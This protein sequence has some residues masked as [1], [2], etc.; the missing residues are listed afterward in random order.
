MMGK[1]MQALA[2][3]YV[4]AGISPPTNAS[5]SNPSTFRALSNKTAGIASTN[6]L[7]GLNANDGRISKRSESTGNIRDKTTSH[8]A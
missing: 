6:V 1:I 7:E 3:L 5:V 2:T 8:D 4:T